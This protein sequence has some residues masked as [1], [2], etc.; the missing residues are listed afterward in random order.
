MTAAEQFQSALEADAQGKHQD[1]L[2][3]LDA[4]PPIHR[5]SYTAELRR[6]NLLFKLERYPEAFEAYQRAVNRH[7]AS[8]EARLASMLAGMKCRKWADVVKIGREVLTRDPGNS[9]ATL[10]VAFALHNLQLHEE[11]ANLF[12]HLLD[13]YPS[14]TEVRAG[15]GLALLRVGKKEEAIEEFQKVL[16]V[17]PK[18]GP[19]KE[20]L[21]AAKE[22]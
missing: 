17:A 2:N 22:A 13:S 9:L 19:A 10:R 11:A 6:G 4:M 7:P 3:T 18:Y 12:R 14:D 8:V 5:D 15:L 21:K 16:D 1:A 20:G